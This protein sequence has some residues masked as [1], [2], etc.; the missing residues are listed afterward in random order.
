ML[1]KKAHADILKV[2]LNGGSAMNEEELLVPTPISETLLPR[3]LSPYDMLM[4]QSQKMGKFATKSYDVTKEFLK[5][6]VVTL[7]PDSLLFG[8]TTE[9]VAASEQPVRT[10]SARGSV[11]DIA[12]RSHQILAAAQTVILPVNLFPD[13][14]VVDRTKVTIT[15]RAFF[16]SA[17]VI[18][19][20]IE[21]VLNITTNTGP[22]FGSLTVSS[23]VMNSTDHYEINYLWR[24]DA[25][26]LKEI[27]Q[28]YV[29]CQHNKIETA[30]LSRQELVDT[31]LEIGKDSTY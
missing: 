27:I 21:D 4:R 20:R 25:I 16:W 22:L 28:G 13:S 8:R 19:V 9:N 2:L 7:H 1:Y 24:K 17:Q 10:V 15:K 29:I 12:E 18:T 30:H 11:H 31:L 26:Y 5:Q 23:R 6:D 3:K 14:I